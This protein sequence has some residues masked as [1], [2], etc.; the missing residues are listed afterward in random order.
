[1]GHKSSFKRYEKK[2]LISEEQFQVLQKRLN[3]KMGPDPYLENLICNIYFDTPNYELIRRSLEKPKYKEKLRLRCYEIPNDETTSF[4]EIKKKF[5]GIVYKRRIA[6]PY[7]KAYR[8]LYQNEELEQSTQISKEIDWFC[9]FYD[10]LAPAMFLSYER[11]SLIGLEDPKLRITFDK[12]II[13]RNWDMEL[14]YGVWGEELLEPGQR[15]MEIKFSMAMP[16]WLARELDALQIYSTSFSKY[17]KAYTNLLN[18]THIK[19]GVPCA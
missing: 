13:Y 6:M 8:Y 9:R 14:D 10:N 2:Y 16:L 11:T 15:L 12:N 19:G 17:G 5:K 18:E 4:I 7:R 3:K 1:M